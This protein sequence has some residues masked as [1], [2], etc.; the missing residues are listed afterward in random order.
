[1]RRPPRSRLPSAC[2][3]PNPELDGLFKTPSLRN[4]ALSAPYGHN[5]HFKTLKDIVHFYNTRDVPDAG[6]PEPEVASNIDT[7]NMGDLGLSDG[8]VAPAP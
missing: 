1:M 4:V 7:V 3:E 5:G 6:W 8:F 2:R